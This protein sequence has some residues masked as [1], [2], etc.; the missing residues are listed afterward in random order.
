MSTLFHAPTNSTRKLD[1]FRS[2]VFR[3]KNQI[4]KVDTNSKALMPTNTLF[5]TLLTANVLTGSLEVN[6]LTTTNKPEHIVELKAIKTRIRVEF[7]ARWS[8]TRIAIPIVN[9][10][11]NEQINIAIG[12]LDYSGVLL[13]NSLI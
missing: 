13:P 7:L 8:L 4:K 6:V 12:H 10:I 5:D 9:T 11:K 3:A 2:K 1:L